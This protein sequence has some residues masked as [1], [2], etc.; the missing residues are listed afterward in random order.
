MTEFVI[1]VLIKSISN[2]D[3]YFGVNIF[4]FSLVKWFDLNLDTYDLQPRYK[5]DRLLLLNI[6]YLIHSFI[7]TNNSCTLIHRYLIVKKKY[8]FI[9]LTIIYKLVHTQITVAL[10]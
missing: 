7:R 2:Q 5:I 9:N 10:N 4:E 8:P 6:V 1:N 3:Y